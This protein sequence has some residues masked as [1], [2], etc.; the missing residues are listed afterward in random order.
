MAKKKVTEP[1]EVPVKVIPKDPLQEFGEF[2][3]QRKALMRE[4]FIELIHENHQYKKFDCRKY[5][6]GNSAKGLL[7]SQ[8][9]YEKY[10]RSLFNQ[11]LHELKNEGVLFHVGGNFWALIKKD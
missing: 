8:I 6:F 10:D 11:I 3:D 2:M 5:C 7:K 4:K 1:K 9:G